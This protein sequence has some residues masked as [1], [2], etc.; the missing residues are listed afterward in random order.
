MNASHRGLIAAVALLAAGA[1]TGSP[2]SAREGG[3]KAGF[4]TCNVSS[5]WGLIFGSFRSIKCEYSPV[6]GFSESYTGAINKFGV[7]IG[8][9]DSGVIVWAVL[10]PT[11]IIAPGALAGNYAGVTGSA[12]V[13]IGGGA[14]VLVG[15]SGHH[16]TLQPVSME[17]QIG[18]NVA[19]GVASL[20]LK[21]ENAEP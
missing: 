11:A 7:D 13:A 18:L 5:G 2:A 19:V 20:E 9:L 16:F 12:A 6:A 1:V 8:Y 15:G 14:Y 4:L 10:A 3:V 17:G 21:A